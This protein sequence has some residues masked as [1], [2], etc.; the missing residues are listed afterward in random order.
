MRK[1]WLQYI[2]ESLLK[3][4]K[5]V[6]LSSAAG[7]QNT[8]VSR[9][10]NLLT[11]LQEFAE[12]SV[13]KGAPTNGIEQ[14]FAAHIQVHP[15]MLSQIKSSRPISDKLATQIENACKRPSGWMALAHPNQKASPREEAF[16]SLA[17]EVWRSKNAK[18]KRD[19]ALALKT[20]AL[21]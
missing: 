19:L 11:L 4:H 1:H 12:Q 3:I 7:K 18:G 17:R 10:I 6:S 2:F 5:M 13:A 9:R 21:Q 14:S 15:S 8:T 20:M 16:V